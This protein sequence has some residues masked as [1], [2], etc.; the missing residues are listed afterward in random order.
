[1]TTKLLSVER[2]NERNFITVECLLAFDK[3]EDKEKVLNLMRKFSSMVRFAYK[4]LL[5]KMERKELKKMLSQKYGIN[6]RYSDSAIFLAQQTLDSCTQRGQ[7]PKKLVFGSRV[8]FEKLKKKHLTGKSR[9]KLRQKWKERR[10]GFL[11]SRGDKSKEGNLNLRLV[12]LNN[13]WHLRINLGNGEYVWAEVVRSAKR[14]KD[15]WIDLVWDLTQAERTGNWF[16]YTVRLKLKNG[17]IYAQISKEEK[18]PEITITK[19]NGVIGIDINAYPFHLALAWTSR[20]GNLEKYERISLNG[21]LD[22][23]ADKRD[24]LSW[25][26]AHQVVEIAKREGKAIVVENLEK[27]PKGRRGDGMPKLRQKLQKWIYKG[28]LEKIEIV[29]KREGVQLI[30]VNPAYTSVIGKLKYAPI[31]RIDKDVAGAYVIAR[32]GLGFKE[33]LL[34]NYRKLLE[35]KEFLSYSVAKIEDR[36]AKLKKEIKE[37]ENEHKRNKLKSR[38]KRLRK[39]LKLLLRYLWDSGKSEPATQQAV[40]RETKPMRGRA[41]SLQKSWRVLSVALAFSCLESFRDFS[42]LKRVILLGDWVGV[43]KRKGL[44]PLPGQGTTAQNMCSFV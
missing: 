3:D 36:I 22:G 42:P 11:Y 7:N 27:V 19:E 23:N 21:L 33:S 37:E 38:L 8:V 40:N 35:D 1:M 16:A 5:D 25:Q 12:N 43:A 44:V 17:K 6:T 10:Y 20:D 32:R 29:G 14:E 24:Y 30:K 26:I 13:Q 4:R 28:L 9:E 34:K 39:E 41:K 15:K 2:K 18:F 31:Y